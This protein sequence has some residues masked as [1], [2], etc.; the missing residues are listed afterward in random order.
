MIRSGNVQ[1]GGVKWLSPDTD[2]HEIID[3]PLSPLMELMLSDI[4]RVNFLCFLIGG[5]YYG[6]ALARMDMVFYSWGSF[7]PWVFSFCW[8][9]KSGEALPYFTIP[10]RLGS[11]RMVAP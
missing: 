5:R 3:E 6:I 11:M 7:R 4:V 1:V 2:E 10:A 9:A 8:A